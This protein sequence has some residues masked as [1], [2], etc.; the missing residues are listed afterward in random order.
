MTQEEKEL[1]LK[2]LAQRLPYRVMVHTDYDAIDCPPLILKY[3]SYN[4]EY[5]AVGGDYTKLRGNIFSSY[6]CKPYLRPMYDMTDDE[7]MEERSLLL[8]LCREQIVN[9]HIYI[10]WLNA[11][12]LDYRGLIAKGLAFEAPEGMYNY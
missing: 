12:Y 8:D 1:L 11:H 10:D 5:Y 6:P 7:I 2:D 9:Q 3:L 4:G